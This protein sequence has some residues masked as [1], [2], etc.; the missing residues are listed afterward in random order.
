MQFNSHWLSMDGNAKESNAPFYFCLC[1]PPSTPPR[2]EGRRG[3]V[4][5]LYNKSLGLC[6]RQNN[7]AT[8]PTSRPPYPWPCCNYLGYRTLGALLVTVFFRFH[9]VS[10]LQPGAQRAEETGK[11]ERGQGDHQTRPHHW[12]RYE[13]RG[14]A[15]KRRWY[16]VG[17]D[18]TTTTAGTESMPPGGR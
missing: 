7:K 17:H 10:A 1:L 6:S 9:F 16:S 4:L 11:S 18:A 5:I 8:T 15:A 12:P 3:S 14:H 13:Q 2:A